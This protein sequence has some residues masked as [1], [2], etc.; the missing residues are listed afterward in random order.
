M[1][2]K[3]AAILAFSGTEKAPKATVKNIEFFGSLPAG[4]RLDLPGPL[5]GGPPGLIYDGF[6]S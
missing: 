4:R 6:G 1:G 2:S 5:K 3:R